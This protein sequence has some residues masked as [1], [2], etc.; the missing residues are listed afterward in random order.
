MDPGILTRVHA[1][2]VA[3]LAPHLGADWS[4][5]GAGDWSARDVALHLAD[6]YFAHAARVVG[7]PAEWF[8]PAT[9]TV[10]EP[11]EPERIVQVIGA[12]AG[13]L[14]CAALD[15]DP[16]SRAY[17]PWG[18]SDPAGSVAMGAAEGLVHT[19]DVAN[20]LGSGWRPPDDLAAP[21]VERLF[22]DAPPDA[23]PGDALLWCTGRIALPG[24][25]QRTTWRWY[26]APPR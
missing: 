26:A 17:H 9:L 20:A 13:L 10:D 19:W 11:Q 22:P 2:T 25:P 8:V 7:Q 14:R 1:E 18:T 16:A 23:D 3:A 15:A 6:A 5:P 24:H 12:S 21:V 4:V